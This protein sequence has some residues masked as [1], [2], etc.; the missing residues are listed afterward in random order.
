M[1]LLEKA[2]ERKQ[3]LK[4]KKEEKLIIKDVEKTLIDLTVREFRDQWKNA[5]WD[6]MG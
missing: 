1:G 6:I 3:I 4:N 2:Q 5:I